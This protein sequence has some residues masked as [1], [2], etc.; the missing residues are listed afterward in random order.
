ME[1]L[2]VTLIMIIIPRVTHAATFLSCLG[3]PFSCSITGISVIINSFVGLLVSLGAWFVRIGLTFNEGVVNAPPVQSGFSVSLAIANLGFVLAIIVIAIAT[4]L[5]RE[6]YGIKQILWKLVVAAILVNFSLVIAGAIL[7]FSNTLTKYF[8]DAISPTANSSGVVGAVADYEGFVT[9]LTAAFEPQSFFT[10]PSFTSGVANAVSDATVGWISTLLGAFMSI[11]FLLLIAF[12]LIAL[13]V[14]LLIRYAYM[15]LLLIVAPLAWLL[16]IFPNTKSNFSKWWN[17]FFRWTFFPPIVIFFLYLAILT[18]T[19]TNRN[20]L[21]NQQLS[22]PNINGQ[23]TEVAVAS[24]AMGAPGYMSSVASDIVMV[25]LVLGGLFMANQ[26]A[27]MGASTAMGMAKSTGTFLQGYATKQG[28]KLGGAAYR[29]VGLVGAREKLQKGELKG[30]GRLMPARLQ[31]ITG[32]GMSLLERGGG[33]DL[34]EGEKK[35]ASQYKNPTE[36]AAL[37]AGSL[38]TEK[39]IALLKQMTD[40]DNL[41]YAKTIGGVDRDEFIDKNEKTFKDYGQVKFYDKEV[42]RALVN[43]K[44]QEAAKAAAVDPNATV[45]DTR[46][47]MGGDGKQIVKAIDLLN[48]SMKQFVQKQEK[49]DASKIDLNYLF[50][51]DTLKNGATLTR[52]EAYL[53]KVASYNPQL[54]PGMMSRMKGEQQKEFVRLYGKAIK[55]E[56]TELQNWKPTAPEETAERDNALKTIDK[57]D[58]NL[59]KILIG[60]ATYGGAQPTTAAPAPNP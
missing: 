30:V 48:A 56:T 28:K 1:I 57:A 49:S 20:Y 8:M 52:M 26:L 25:V 60:L 21:Q 23:P 14:M 42:Q 39:R 44:A 31:S 59:K 5:R 35:W 3:S 58:E 22:A 41:E 18:A 9:K 37:L 16:W 17:H 32:R 40:D 4:I 45:V 27:I 53:R 34:V 47:V 51:K 6:S 46:K 13:A 11:G 7:G 54:V 36:A 43:V 33:S 29:G 2:A 50:K 19:G 10:P 38:P 55:E 15:V 24:A 12:T